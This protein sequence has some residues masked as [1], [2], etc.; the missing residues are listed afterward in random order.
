MN[1]STS[2]LKRS[3][4]HV[5]YEIWMFLEVTHNLAR[6]PQT[7]Q[8]QFIRNAYLECF[9]THLRNLLEFFYIPQNKRHQADDIL[10][11]DYLKDS[12][13][14]KRNRTP[15]SQLKYATRRV[16]KQIAHLTYHRNRYNKRTKPWQFGRIHGQMLPTIQAFYSTLPSRR[17]NWHHFIELNKI[18][19]A[20]ATI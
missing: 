11:E 20:Y 2:K 19:N 9:A 13:T 16:D 18:T 8:Y 6:L 3:A 17:K 12:R 1:I 5:F 10:A 15:F 14:F 4:E 7:P